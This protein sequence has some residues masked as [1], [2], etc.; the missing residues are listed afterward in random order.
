MLMTMMMCRL[1][2]LVLLPAATALT[3]PQPLV[4]V[5]FDMDGTLIRPCIDFSDM[6]RRIYEVASEDAGYLVNEGDVVTMV[7]KFSPLCMDKAQVIFADI[8]AKALRDMQVMPGMM[9]LCRYLDDNHIKRAVLTRNVERS[10]DYLQETFMNDLAQFSPQVARDTLDEE[11][12]TL[13]AKPCPDGIQYICRQWQCLPSQTIMVGDSD[14][15]DV[16]AGN[17]AGCGATIHLTTG[18]DNDSG[19]NAGEQSLTEERQATLTIDALETLQGLLEE[20]LSAS[21]VIR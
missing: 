17:R 3:L 7:D 21:R 11:G 20:A 15:D 19:R 14:E 8:E 9:E 4:G 6:R 16:V 5:I 2:L 18:K 12:N 13:L 1:L 10:V